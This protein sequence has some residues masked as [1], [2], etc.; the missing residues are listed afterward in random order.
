MMTYRRAVKSCKESKIS[1]SVQANWGAHQFHQQKT[2]DFRERDKQ[3]YHL[4]HMDNL[5][6]SIV[7]SVPLALK[8]NGADMMGPDDTCMHRG[9]LYRAEPKGQSPE[10]SDQAANIVPSIK[11]RYLKV[12]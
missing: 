5:S 9:S 3:L 12:V 1:S 4:Q 11:Q 8:P 10:L 7:P 6:T 2:K